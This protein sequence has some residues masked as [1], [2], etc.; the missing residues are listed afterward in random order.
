MLI[1]CYIFPHIDIITQHLNHLPVFTYQYTFKFKYKKFEKPRIKI[2]FIKLLK[3][4][5]IQYQC[6]IIA[7]VNS[8]S[9]KTLWW[10]E[11]ISCQTTKLAD[12]DVVLSKPII[13]A[14]CSYRHQFTDKDITQFNQAFNAVIGMQLCPF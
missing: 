11:L 1:Q 7:L 5:H 12:G 14:T 6:I 13:Y 3:V 10:F 4:V 9:C 8:T 2:N